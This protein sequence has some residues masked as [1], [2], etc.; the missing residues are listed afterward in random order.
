MSSETQSLPSSIAERCLNAVPART[1]GVR[2]PATIATRRP[3]GG[4]PNGGMRRNSLTFA[5]M[6]ALVA[7]RTERLEA[8]G[9]HHFD[10]LVIGGGIT[11]C[12]IAYAAASRGLVVALVDKADFAW[13]TS[14]R[15]SRL[16]HGGVRYLEHGHLHLVF[17]SS[18]ERRTL[19][20]I[21][22]TVVRHL[23]FRWPVYRDARVPLWKLGIG[24]FMYDALAVFRNVQ[25]HRLLT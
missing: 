19:L 4:P 13:G 9:R 20:R 24:L 16:V 6:Q 21:A 17:E 5:S 10:L 22:P 23:R 1:K 18:R 11:G 12:G 25:R 8:L 2:T 15:S 3:G 7:E 14:S